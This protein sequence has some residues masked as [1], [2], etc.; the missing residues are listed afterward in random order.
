MTSGQGSSSLYH[1]TP[2]GTEGPDPSPL[3]HGTKDYAM[4]C[5]SSPRTPKDLR[6]NVLVSQ[7]DQSTWNLREQVRLLCTRSHMASSSGGSSLC[8][9]IMAR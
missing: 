9:T 1:T 4:Y 2:R 8:T 3:P 6:A 7:P 5:S